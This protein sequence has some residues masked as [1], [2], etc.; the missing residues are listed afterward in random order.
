MQDD[1]AQSLASLPLNTPMAEPPAMVPAA[2]LP[3]LS[4][5]QKAAV[6]VKL[7]INEG[8][9]LPLKDL[10]E[11]EQ[12]ALTNQMSRMRLV[13]RGTLQA[14][15]Q[16]FLD[17]LEEVGLHFPGG[18]EGALGTLEDH[19][20]PA[21]AARLRREAGIAAKGDPWERISCLANEKLA[22]VLEREAIEVGAVML[23][24]LDTAKSAEIL[25]HLPGDRARQVSLA[26]SRTGK[27]APETVQRIGL[28][29]AGQLD[30]EP[31]NAFDDEPVERIG[32]ILNFSRAAVRD[33]VMAGLEEAD[34][35]F[36]AAVKK[37]IFT[38]E[39]VP[40]RIASRDIPKIV[41]GLDQKLLV[42][43]LAFASGPTEAARDF[44]LNNMSQRMAD[45]LR[46]EMTELGEIKPEAGE[47]ATNALVAEIRA[48]ADAGEILLVAE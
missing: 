45:T 15:A 13:D 2:P 29:L 32:A 20:N 43:A 25:S 40:Q 21:T 31:I 5:M 4:P 14:V 33:D 30:A 11:E 12:E 48:L 18:L 3:S 23:S 36:A 10:S 39:N 46:E 7:L 38:F 28:S 26:I 35:D 1:I 27:I 22:E 34:S 37:S 41:R 42:T 19:L 9:E 16:E 44:V 17:E 8:L 6:V 47:E 24:K